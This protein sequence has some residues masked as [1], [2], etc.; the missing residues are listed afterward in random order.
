MPRCCPVA[1]QQQGEAGREPDLWG[2]P[3]PCCVPSF[4]CSKGWPRRG[5]VLWL[6]SAEPPNPPDQSSTF[7]VPFS[8]GKEPLPAAGCLSFVFF[9]AQN[10]QLLLPERS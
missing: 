9:C 2:R 7:L 1:W 4:P 5:L 3:G 6:G 10:T 8:V